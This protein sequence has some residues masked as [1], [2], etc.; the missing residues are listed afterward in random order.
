MDNGV[1]K[2]KNAV[3]FLLRGSVTVKIILIGF[4]TLIL[5]IPAF[6]IM[7]LIDERQSRKAEA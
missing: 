2:I 6:Q 3:S 5:Q 4:M 1:D 7:R